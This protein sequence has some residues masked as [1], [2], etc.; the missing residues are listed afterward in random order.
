MK[1]TKIPNR[2]INEKSPYLLQHA[3]NPVD[4]HPWNEEAFA[5][6]KTE[7]KPIFLSIGYS[8]CHWCH[9]MERESF[10]DNEVAE[11]LNRDFVA[12]KVD[13]EERPDI[14]NIYMQVCQALVGH[15][16]WP[17]TIFMTPEKKPF[18][19][20]TYIPKNN[21]QG[22]LG[23]ME[24]LPRIIELWQN[25]RQR[26]EDA[27][28]SL[29]DAMNREERVPSS[30]LEK[31]IFSQ[32]LAYLL[33]NF[34]QE[35]GGFTSAPKFPSPHTIYYLLRHYY[36]FQD[37]EAL[38][39]VEKTLLAMYQG[40]IYDHIGGG[41]ARY[42]TDRQWLV[43]HFEKMLYDNALLSLAYLEAYQITGK[44]IY[45]KVAREIFTYILR[46]MTSPEGGFYS[47][48]DADSE[49]VEG[50]YYVWTPQEIKAALGEEKGDYFCNLYGITETG[51]FEGKSIPHLLELPDPEEW[52]GLDEL[53][54]TLLKSRK[55]RIPPHLDDKILSSWNGMMIASLSYGARILN[56]PQYLAAASRAA[57]F[58]LAKMRRSDGRLLARYR[59]G[60]ALYPAYALDYAT[61]IWALLEL[62]S[63]SF[64]S[65]Y[66]KI[67]QELNK[68]LLRYFWDE[69]IGGL[70]FY[71]SDAEQLFTR[72]KE[73][74]DGAMPSDNSVAALNFLRLGRLTGDP[75]LVEKAEETVNAF[76]QV[77]NR[78][79]TGFTYLLI[80]GLYLQQPSREIV[81]VGEKEHRDT[82]AM[83]DT[84]NHR[85]LPN[86]VVLLKDPLDQEIGEIAPFVQ[87]MTEINGQATAYICQNFTCQQPTTDIKEMES[88]LT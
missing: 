3:Y 21:R 4:W 10:E 73:G 11:L 22:A 39:M 57:D 51:N 55:Q 88:L 71:G 32:T 58:I 37:E 54:K 48:Q 24:L 60:E 86:T 23:L 19:A 75:E 66:L 87:E 41:F 77:I 43:P 14:D 62:Y 68:D 72:P 42:S 61:I 79:P 1:N 53:K 12:I 28:Q 38:Q 36:F 2:L 9:V 6:A 30:T 59:D 34:D 27:S 40:G 65:R 85:F 82:Q 50:K 84:I 80:T 33:H 76:A 26:I 20:A 31:N 74:Y 78:Y 56:E 25:D 69:N 5:K 15:G 63:T 8:T 29:V 47:A 45:A 17:L 7:D 35:W 44:K 64:N 49:G 70:F 46:D 16:G 81:I 67:A 13:R 52:A 18:F 83:L